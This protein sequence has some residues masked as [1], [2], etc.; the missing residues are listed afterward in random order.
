M[1]RKTNIG[2]R[3]SRRLRELQP[4]R[5]W[6][7]P[8]L[9][10]GV[11]VLV[12]TLIAA[13]GA[14]RSSQAELATPV[15][16]MIVNSESPFTPKLTGFGEI[17]SRHRWQ[18]I[19]QLAGKIAW[20]HP[21]LDIGA[22][23]SAGTRLIEIEPLDYEVAE[24]RAGAQL[25]TALAAQAEV[26]SRIEDLA[27][28]IEIETRSLAIAETRYARNLE[29]SAKGHI[30]KLQLDAEERELLRQKQT[31]QNLQ[32]QANLLP[33]QQR[34]A[35][36]RVAEAQAELGK[37]EEDLNRTVFT[38]PFDGRI[39]EL[40]AEIGQ[41]VP[42]GRSMLGAHSTRSMELLVE[43]PY[44]HLLARFPLV[45]ANPVTMARPGD[46][47]S[48]QIRYRTS[49]GEL[50][51]D[52][53]V[54]RIDTGLNAHS[55]SAQVY[56]EVDLDAADFAPAANLYVEVEIAGPL[57]DDHIVIP[58]L[59]WH[60]GEVLIVDEDNRL[61]RRQVTMAFAEADQVILSEGLQTGDRLILSDLL[62]PAEGMLVSPIAVEETASL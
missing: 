31:L 35:A 47:L 27:K 33:A 46:A 43:V 19:A 28:A 52:G 62:F 2:E 55:R 10:V 9:L 37:A 17:Q 41:Y 57:L 25:S 26:R 50:Y 5:W 20:R 40:D 51:W 8:P 44:E 34:A 12:A 60:A 48:A 42:A 61:R 3:V 32:T 22:T 4:A 23:F 58:R 21:D 11:L 24:S 15:R 56:V 6:F 54:S 7:F 30:S 18:A 1:N 53:H 13:P 49:S 36:A 59:A 16:V 39:T 29:L 14:Q 38:M 45:M